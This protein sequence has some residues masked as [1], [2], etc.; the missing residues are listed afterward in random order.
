MKDNMTSRVFAFPRLGWILL[1][2]LLVCFN[3]SSA[4]SLREQEG[5]SYIVDLYYSQESPLSDV[6]SEIS[7]FRSQYPDS[8]YLIYLDFLDANIA[9]AQLDYTRSKEYFTRLLDA[10]LPPELT[11]DVY[12]NA[13]V[14]SY[15]LNEL[16]SA[17][18][19][20]DDLTRIT[21]DEYY[22]RQGHIWLGRIF[23]LQNLF[24]SAEQEYKA[25]QDIG[26]GEVTY[27]YF[28]ILLEL[29]KDSDATQ[30][31]ESIPTTC[32][33]YPDFLSAWLD[34][35][36]S[37][38]QYNSFDQIV[39]SIQPSDLMSP[40]IDLV[41]IRRALESNDIKSASAL[42]DSLTTPS[43]LRSFYQA[44]L[45]A[46]SDQYSAADSIYKAIQSSSDPQLVYQAYLERHKILYRIEPDAAIEQLRTFLQ[47]P[48]NVKGEALFLLGSFY[49]GQKKYPEALG[50]YLKAAGSNIQPVLADKADDR[51]AETLFLYGQKEESKS[52]YSHYLNI[53]PEGRFRDKAMY[54]IGLS[55]YLNK[56]LSAAKDIWS[57]LQEQYTDSRWSDKSLFLL[58]EIA[59]TRSEYSTAES[60]Y[61]I[62]LTK[63]PD[64]PEVLLR[65]AQCKYYQ[66]NYPEAVEI[67]SR[68][69]E[70][71]Q[72][73]ESTILLAGI[74]FSQRQYADALELY[75]LA[76]RQTENKA[77]KT[78]ARS[79]QAYTLFYLQKFSEAADLFTELSQD[80]P[81]PD[82][83]LFQAAKAATQANQNNRALSLYDKILDEYPD[84][85]YYLQALANEANLEFNAG[86]Y[87]ESLQDWLNIL[88]RFS[89]NTY[90]NEE[91]LALLQEV[92]T[93]IEICCRRLDD[94]A[95]VEEIADLIDTFQSDYIKF[96][97]EY[98]IVKLYANN[99]LWEQVLNEATKLR[100]SLNL[101]GEKRND[102]DQLM[103]ESL[104]KLEQFSTADSLAEEINQ[105]DPNRETLVK[106]GDLAVLTGKNSLALERYSSAFSLQP[107][108]GLWL[109]MLEFSVKH[110]YFG[111]LAIWDMG[112]VY[113]DSLPGAQLHRLSFLF[114][115][116]DLPAAKS[117]ADSLLEYESGQWYRAQSEL[118]LGRIALEEL[119]YQAALRY[120]RKVKT[121]YPDFTDTYGTASYWQIIT[122][123]QQGA[124]LEARLTFDKERDHLSQEQIAELDQLFLQLR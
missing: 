95:F 60:L 118:W 86:E 69:P 23:A 115:N 99:D 73:F 119:D 51:V 75:F 11:A 48:K 102:I 123:I 21:S 107:D 112:A 84:S 87:E 50:E 15:Y 68:L 105:N 10:T 78:E 58:A 53:R 43:D 30:I 120:F 56:D 65:V 117:V 101:P 20:L 54:Y 3:E 80:N 59:F 25:A 70:Y 91:E 71:S 19:L 37:T 62:V 66:N 31:L 4:Q 111:F 63:Y 74:R 64:D 72:G 83:Y 85:G 114:A 36:V 18:K 88:R 27:D 8:D 42:L 82:M 26:L 96:E 5:F 122:L 44:N 57:S 116:K 55:D 29:G 33:A 28:L 35:L 38:E 121:L 46:L 113:A 41:R 14:C 24:L 1:V 81:E 22:L 16:G 94:P 49:S 67:L 77:G 2:L 89:S 40:A 34:H 45:L 52:A 93:G 76:E 103:L 108:K 97:L 12:L 39:E 104:I 7:L 124:N 106:W 110:D 100:G 79:Y 98:I 6:Q 92:F 17:Q 61:T 90:V 109:H 47:A 32:L 9:L 13:A